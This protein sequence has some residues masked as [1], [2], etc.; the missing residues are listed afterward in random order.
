MHLIHGG[1]VYSARQKM[2]QEPLDF[3]ANI[4]PM[5]MPP[6]AVRAAADA[7][8]QCTQYPDPLCRELRAALAAYE[9]IPAEQIVCGNG[10]ADLIFRIVAATHPQRALLL[11]PTFAE[12]EQALRSMDCSIAYFPL[13]ESEGFVL[14]EA[15]LQQLTP[16]INLLFLCNPNNPT[17]RTV[18]PALLQEIWKRCEEAGILLV[19]DE[20]FNEFLE[21][22]EQNTLKDVLETGANA[23]ILKAFTKSFAMPGLRLGYGLCGNR[24]LA[25]R[26]FSCGQPW[27]VSIPAQAAGVAALQEQGYLERMRRLI[28][29][30]RRWLSENLARLGLCVFPSEANYIL[31]RT[32][33]EIPLR[34]R[35]EQRG[36]LIRACGN[37]RGLDN[38][39]YRIAV[40]G[41]G[42]NER[43]IA[44]LKCA[45]EE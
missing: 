2:K 7:L 31:F 43:L 44:A 29:T 8:Q 19:V 5:G 21:H 45:L 26:I 15:F 36:V 6:G 38:R 13:Q 25:E 24:D 3:S 22:P 20:C 14:P 17:G 11:E 28:Q 16:E 40:R 10:A 42:E 1:D 9:G 33:T 27:G 32:E 23:V 39:Y 18:S 30:E 41:H 37:Y 34:E 12:Y 35:M 4:N